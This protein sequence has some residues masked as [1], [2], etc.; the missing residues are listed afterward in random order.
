MTGKKNAASFFFHDQRVQRAAGALRAAAGKTTLKKC[1]PL[2]TQIP[3]GATVVTRWTAAA[4]LLTLL[5]KNLALHRDKTLRRPPSP[6]PAFSSVLKQS[7]HSRN[8][9]L[10]KS[11]LL[12][13]RPAHLGLGPPS[14]VST[15]AK[16]VK[17]NPAGE[18]IRRRGPNDRTSR[19]SAPPENKEL[20][21]STAEVALT[22]S[23]R[24]ATKETSHYTS[25]PCSGSIE[26]FRGN[27]KG[28]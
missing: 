11:S 20:D 25:P 14:P 28:H 21:K 13:R 24:S 17:R 19:A 5:Q 10:M 12:L 27:T 22:R 1:L 4:L 2:I 7:M 3:H 18:T 23:L 16:A 6:P 15:H 9:R 8:M 26:V